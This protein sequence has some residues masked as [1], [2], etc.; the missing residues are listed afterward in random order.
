MIS[1]HAF[2]DRAELAEH[3]IASLDAAPRTSSFALRATEDKTPGQGERD[4]GEAPSARCRRPKAGDPDE[5]RGAMQ[6]AQPCQS[7][8]PMYIG[9]GYM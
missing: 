4:A 6:D 9:T 5:C 2:T 8:V 7:H 1:C 3:L